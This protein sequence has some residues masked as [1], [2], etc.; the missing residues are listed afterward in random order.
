MEQCWKSWVRILPWWGYI[1]IQDGYGSLPIQ[2]S[3]SDFGW[4]S[5][6]I[7]QYIDPL[8]MPCSIDLPILGCCFVFWV[9]SWVLFLQVGSWEQGWIL[10][11]VFGVVFAVGFLGPGLDLCGGFGCCFGCC[12]WL[13]CFGCCFLGAV[14]GCVL[15]AVFWVLFFG[16]CFRLCF[17]CCFLGAVLG[18]VF[19]CCVLGA[20]FWVLF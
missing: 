17:G 16:C 11:V 1:T 13:L 4:R 12:F 14:L 19:G 3:S 2:P 6:R 10:V 5:W 20:V 15:G 7:P 8:H 9:L 18:C